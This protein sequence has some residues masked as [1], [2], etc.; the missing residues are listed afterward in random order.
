M[1]TSLSESAKNIESNWQQ[2]GYKAGDT[3]AEDYF[4]NPL[5][6]AITAINAM[7]LMNATAQELRYLKLNSGYAAKWCIGVVKKALS[8][9]F[10]AQKDDNDTEMVPYAKINEIVSPWW[11]QLEKMVTYEREQG[12]GIFV[13]YKDGE[14][15]DK[16]DFEKP[17]VV[18]DPSKIKWWAP[19]V[20]EC[21][22]L[23]YKWY[24]TDLH[25]QG[26]IQYNGFHICDQRIEYFQTVPK[27]HTYF[28]TSTLSLGYVPLLVLKL[29]S[30]GALNRTQVWAVLKFLGQ[31]DKSNFM[32]TQQ[33]RN[34]RDNFLRGDM[35]QLDS[36]D[37][38]V[39]L[40]DKGQSGT[41]LKDLMLSELAAAWGVPKMAFEGTN[42]GSVTGSEVNMTFWGEVIVGLQSDLSQFM[43]N[44]FRKWYGMDIGSPD[45]NVDFYTSREKQITIE[46]SEVQ[47]EML[48]IQKDRMKSGVDLQAIGAMKN[49]IPNVLQRTT[50]R[51]EGKMM[52]DALQEA[53]QDEPKA[54]SGWFGK[55]RLFKR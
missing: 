35:L 28:G 39:Q 12:L 7:N 36:T 29:I 26:D 25:D 40:G 10:S 20:M 15:I 41:E 2:G 6:D 11:A 44:I 52:M 19:D 43:R 27:E 53:K 13:A 5:T 24:F 50:G 54:K 42:A 33:F 49:T 47:L 55:I 31:V 48:K 45:W 34:F 46:A 4:V 1:T 30:Q 21:Y 51:E 8:G 22:P 3:R 9:R 16:G 38:I 18:D 17:L 32:K 37:K 23:L 14:Q